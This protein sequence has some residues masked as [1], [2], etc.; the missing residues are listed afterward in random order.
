MGTF[1]EHITQSRNNLD[2]LSKVNTNINNSWDWQV[3]VCFYSAL[4]L[5]NAHIVSKTHKN[6]LSHNQVAEVIN[7][8]NSLSV[9]KLDEETYLSYNKLVQLSRR[10]R[11]LLSENFTKK[12]IVDVQPACIT[13]SKHFKKSIYHL[14][15]VLSFICKNY[16]VN[17]GKI[18]ISCIDLKGLEYTYFT[19]S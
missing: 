15:K 6:Y 3:T 7:P 9:A 11:Y 16:N 4:H 12:G 2:F 17:F 8:F 19:I 5:M 18:N 13:Y 10:A 1:A 14:D